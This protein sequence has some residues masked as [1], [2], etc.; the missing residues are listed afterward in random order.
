LQELLQQQQNLLQSR[1][2]LYLQMQ[3]RNR[4]QLIPTSVKSL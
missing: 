3:M 4:D 2:Q 1:M